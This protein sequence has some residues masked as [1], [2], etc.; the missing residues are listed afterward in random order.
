MKLKLS[1][2]SLPVLG[3]IAVGLLAAALVTVIGLN[4]ATMAP[5]TAAALSLPGPGTAIT[6]GAL[7]ASLACLVAIT[8]LLRHNRTLSRLAQ[9]AET[10]AGGDFSVEVPGCARSDALGLLARAIALL[11]AHGEGW[12]SNSK[13]HRERAE[14]LRLRLSC[15]ESA[16]NQSEQGLAV[17]GHDLRLVFCNQRLLQDLKLPQGFATGGARLESLMNSV[18]AG[19]LLARDEVRDHMQ[20]WSELAKQRKAGRSAVPLAGG[21]RLELRMKPDAGESMILLYR[22]ESAAAKPAVEEVQD[23]KAASD[24]AESKAVATARMPAPSTPAT[25]EK[26]EPLPKVAAAP[27]PRE[28]KPLETKPPET[29]EAA[30]P[31]DRMAPPRPMEIEEKPAA[32]PSRGL[33]VLLVE[34][35]KAA[36]LQAITLLDKAGHWVDLTTRGQEAV[37]AVARRRYDAVLLDL[38]LDD[39]TGFDF[40]RLVRRL[41]GEAEQIPI[42]ALAD[43]VARIAD[44]LSVGMDDML[45]RP[46]R[47]EELQQKL[48]SCVASREIEARVAAA[49]PAAAAAADCNRRGAPSL[50]Q[51]QA[52]EWAE[53]RSAMGGD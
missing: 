5:E 27:Q 19:G 16:L 26:S 34:R 37:K 12:R 38:E 22:R 6:L 52:E 13:Q 4:F 29:R 47:A 46:L 8:L 32:A 25:L 43:S 20:N 15:L 49:Q 23:D 17:V 33:R 53:L 40:T 42:I 51:T 35:D 3:R 10:L 50:A 39:M 21:G 2:P 1:L 14:A 24:K 9:T 48:G 31:A 30:P 28:I 41:G 44:C 36:Q 45:L 7:I 11:K 18:A